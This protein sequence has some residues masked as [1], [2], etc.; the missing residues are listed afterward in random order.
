MRKPA[1]PWISNARCQERNSS[2]DSWYHRQASSRVF[3]RYAP[4]RP[5]R[6]CGAPSTSWSSGVAGPPWATFGSAAHRKAC[7]LGD[8]GKPRVQARSREVRGFP[9]R[10]DRQPHSH[11]RPVPPAQS[12]RVTQFPFVSRIFDEFERV[13]HQFFQKILKVCSRN[14]SR[15]RREGRIDRSKSASNGGVC[16]RGGLILRQHACNGRILPTVCNH[17]A[18]NRLPNSSVGRFHILITMRRKFFHDRFLRRLGTSPSLTG[19]NFA[20]RLIEG[21]MR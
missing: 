17:H 5:R 3:R 9:T 12:L 6:P 10:Q 1:R 16:Y 11:C 18:E 8:A 7:L 15:A 19:G 2:S 20:Q 21:E 4:L 13:C 14:R